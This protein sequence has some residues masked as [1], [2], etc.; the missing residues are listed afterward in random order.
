MEEKTTYICVEESEKE[1]IKIAEIVREIKESRAFWRREERE[2]EARHESTLYTDYMDDDGVPDID[3]LH[4]HRDT[5]ISALKK[6]L[7]RIVSEI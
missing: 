4:W 1:V 6:E 2:F 7:S 3:I 5:D